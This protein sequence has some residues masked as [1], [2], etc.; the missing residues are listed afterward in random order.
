M[1]SYFSSKS[2]YDKRS[3]TEMTDNVFVISKDTGQHVKFVAL[4]VLRYLKS[5]EQVNSIDTFTS[6]S[7]SISL[8]FI[9]NIA[10]CQLVFFPRLVYGWL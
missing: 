1:I 6:D 2:A 9:V 8:I 10:T 3:I 4:S 7:Q 5:V